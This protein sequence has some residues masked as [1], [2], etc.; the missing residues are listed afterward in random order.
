MFRKNSISAGRITLLTGLLC[1]AA[2]IAFPARAD[3]SMEELEAR[4]EKA[5]KRNL[6]LKAEILERENIKIEAEA[7][8]SGKAFSPKF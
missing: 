6:Q 4:L 7:I 3:Q 8:K 5:K 1:S 2:F